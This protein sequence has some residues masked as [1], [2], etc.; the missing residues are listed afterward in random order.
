[1]IGQWLL[2]TQA[3]RPHLKTGNGKGRRERR[4]ARDSR[5]E[6]SPFDQGENKCFLQNFLKQPLIFL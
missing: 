3:P 4:L 6:L 2:Q 5:S 1:M